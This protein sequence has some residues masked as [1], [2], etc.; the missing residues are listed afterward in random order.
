MGWLSVSLSMAAN[1]AHAHT[2]GHG[3]RVQEL[4]L[5]KKKIGDLLTEGDDGISVM[6]YLKVRWHL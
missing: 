4:K 5:K 1:I 6:E 3:I 2:P